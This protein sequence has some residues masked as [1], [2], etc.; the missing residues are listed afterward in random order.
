MRKAASV[1]SLIL[2]AGLVADVVGV[3]RSGWQHPG[4][5]I[6]ATV[7][8]ALIINGTNDTPP[9]SKPSVMPVS[10]TGY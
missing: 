10:Q 3:I 7:W 9:F 6:A 4:D 8:L 2:G 5:T 1:W